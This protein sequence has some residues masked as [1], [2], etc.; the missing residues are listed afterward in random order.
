F[1]D[2][3]E[4]SVDGLRRRGARL[5]IATNGGERYIGAVGERLR[6]AERFDRVF[7]H[8]HRGISSKE[9][10]VRVALAELGPGDALFVGDREADAAAARHAGIPFIGCAYGYGEEGELAGAARVVATPEELARLLERVAA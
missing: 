6:Y 9:E 7:Y 3:L 8:G 4:E 2:P 10:M 5:A 1:Y